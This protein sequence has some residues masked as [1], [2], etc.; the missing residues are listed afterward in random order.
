MGKNDVKDLCEF[1]TPFD[2]HI[3]ELVFWLRDFIWKQ[4]P[5]CNELI[6]E[7]YNAVAIGWSP[8]L[9]CRYILLDSR[10]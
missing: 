1:L 8:T 9:R 6:Y 10:L 4:F 2:D 5:K 7:N 3:V